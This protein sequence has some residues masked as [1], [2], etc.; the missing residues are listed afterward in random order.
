MRLVNIFL[1]TESFCLGLPPPQAMKDYMGAA[2]GAKESGD[3]AAVA[4]ERQTW[5]DRALQFLRKRGC[6]DEGRR[7]LAN[8][9]G[10]QP[11]LG[12]WQLTMR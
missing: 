4:S 11:S 7:R 12:A 2:G 1:F 9:I 5:R 3:K 6:S 8:D 10:S